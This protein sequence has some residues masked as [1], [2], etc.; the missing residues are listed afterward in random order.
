MIINKRTKTKDVLPFLTKERLEQLINDVP[1]V[2][3]KKPILSMTCGEFIECL[4]DDYVLGFLKQ[5][6]ALKAFG[7]VKSFRR[8]MEEINKY[9]QAN[10][11]SESAEMKQASINVQFPTFGQSILMTVTEYLRLN[12]IE[13]AA[14]V[15]LSEF[16]MIQRKQSAENK[17]SVNH[18]KILEQRN[19]QKQKHYGKRS[20]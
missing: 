9:L 3:L 6:R 8:Q 2:P 7:M 17:F 18:S 13:D 10:K 16:L 19:K 14:D 11:V 12:R 15:P 4:D 1:E 20:R 5:K